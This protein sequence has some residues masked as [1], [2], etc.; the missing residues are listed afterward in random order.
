M[1]EDV[2][3]SSHR[4]SSF[5]LIRLFALCLFSSRLIWEKDMWWGRSSALLAILFCWNFRSL[6]SVD[7]WQVAAQIS[8][9]RTVMES[10]LLL[11]SQTFSFRFSRCL[12][13]LWLELTSCFKGSVPLWES[14]MLFRST[15]M[16]VVWSH[17]PK[18]AVKGLT[19]AFAVSVCVSIIAT[20]VLIFFL[21]FFFLFSLI[22]DITFSSEKKNTRRESVSLSR[23]MCQQEM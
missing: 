11:G 1:W 22:C 23:T 8:H 19:E 20:R 10:S 15:H 17:L 7:G 13:L 18:T 2:G 12:N 6:E 9:S 5:A 21:S 16:T 3:A 4:A 14:V